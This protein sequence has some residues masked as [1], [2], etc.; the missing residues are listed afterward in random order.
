MRSFLKWI[1]TDGQAVLEENGFNQ[2]V[3]NE[4]NS[5]MEKLT[6]PA[7][8]LET[9]TQDNA[10]SN[11]FLFVLGILLAVGILFSL[12][13]WIRKR[14]ESN[15]IPDEPA[16]V[17][18][19]NE[20]RLAFP[21][22]LYY[23]KTHTWVFMEQEGVVKIGV[24]DFLP[25]ITGNLNCVKMKQPGEFIKK[26]EELFSLVQDGKHLNISS[27]VSGRIRYINE[28]VVEQPELLNKSP[29]NEGWL[30]LVEPSNW[31]RELQFMDMAENYRNWI[32]NEF[33]RLK[34]FLSKSVNPSSLEVA[35]IT[36]QD[37][38]EIS[39][40]PLENLDPRVW[41]DFQ[42]QFIDTAN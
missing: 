33:Q 2:L 18:V 13:L 5:Q 21:G 31:L 10:E 6:L 40:H 19:I 22:G 15:L 1:M 34:D 23:D 25:H 4:R 36:L 17:G 38:G 3:S 16:G 39:D 12:Y 7:G 20:G 9:E 14:R 8:R 41:E 42:K 32:R 29:Y 11:V 26:D 37:G 35:G 30:F 27:P 28:S 24:D